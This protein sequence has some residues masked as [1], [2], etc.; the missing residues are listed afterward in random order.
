MT[1]PAG[2]NLQ[3]LRDDPKILTDECFVAM[4]QIDELYAFLGPSGLA[5]VMAAAKVA[6]YLSFDHTQL[7]VTI[8]GDSFDGYPERLDRFR[9]T[10]PELDFDEAVG[11]MGILHD[12]DTGWIMEGDAS[13]RSRWH[14]AKRFP[15]IEKRG[16]SDDELQALVDQGSWAAERAKIAEIDEQI[17]SRRG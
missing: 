4:E 10:Q 2:S 15:W 1:K 17:L 11:R 7:I 12:I 13:E 16:R 5:N 9:A 14:G 6:R 3:L 8:A